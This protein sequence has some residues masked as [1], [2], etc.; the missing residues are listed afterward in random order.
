[1]IGA[2]PLNAQPRIPLNVFQVIEQIYWFNFGLF[3]AILD[4]ISLT[5]ENG[6][7]F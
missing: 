1:M 3:L 5:S 7:N 2:I 4:K 6:G